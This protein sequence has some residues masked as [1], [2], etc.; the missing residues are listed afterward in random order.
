MLEVKDICKSFGGIR[1]LA[2]VSLEVERGSIVGLIGP[3]GSGKTT[4][5]NIVSGFYP[6][7]SGEVRFKG[8]GIG[9]LPPYEVARRGV[10]RTF[11]V[12]KAPKQMTVLE[13]MLLAC[14][15]QVG[16]NVFGAL[17]K[18]RRTRQQE[19]AQ[20]ERALSLLELTG[21]RHLANEYSGNLSGGQQ[22]LLSLARIL[23]RDPDLVL[24]DEPTAGVNP[25]LTKKFMGFIKELQ[26]EQ[27]KTF[28]LVEHDM[29]LI[30]RVCDRVYVL[31]AGVKI[32]EGTPEEIQENQ[33]VLEAYL[34][35]RTKT[36]QMEGKGEPGV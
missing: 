34:G 21:I 36:V 26:A 4:L 11:Q 9:H 17:L 8:E 2:G 10:V 22:K 20:L 35:G 18:G 6:A 29:N 31:D 33:R 3:N 27:G 5:F 30:S 32:A 23:I 19:G 1:A 25:T 15:G 16:E 24:L 28:L 12:S 7:D 14:D 13:N